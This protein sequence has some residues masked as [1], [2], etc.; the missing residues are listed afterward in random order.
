MCMC[1]CVCF[2]ICSHMNK[3][4]MLPETISNMVSKVW[5]LEIRLLP[6]SQI[7]VNVKTNLA[8]K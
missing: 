6:E 2:Y 7:V 5:Y 4:G 1:V 3:I 8:L